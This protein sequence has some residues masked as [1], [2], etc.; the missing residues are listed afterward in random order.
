MGKRRTT[1]EQLI[2]TAAE[3]FLKR[4]YEKTTMRD[5]AR[6]V[7]IQAPAIYN[8]FKNKK[9]I[10]VHIHKQSREIFRENVIEEMKKIREPQER[11]KLF[12]RRLIQYQ[13]SLGEMVFILDDTI[14]RYYLKGK[15][16][17]IDE[18]FHLVRDTL[19]ELAEQGRL[20][21][22]IDP[23]VAAFALIGMITR[24]YKWYDPKGRL[25]AEEL[26]EQTV[27]LFFKGFKGT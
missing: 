2:K 11:I 5:L 16:E 10:L 12:I 4:G 15:K 26:A 22:G 3:L 24:V 21:T 13:V 17:I 14:P 18:T 19:A 9:E 7:G 20:K 25:G 1:K 8:H 23:T 27:Q 6:I